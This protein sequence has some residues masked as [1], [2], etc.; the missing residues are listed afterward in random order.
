VLDLSSLWAGP[1]CAH[2]LGL[3]GARVVKLESASRPDG[4][5]AGS[6]AFFDLLN[7]GKASV[8]LDLS[9]RAGRDSLRRLIAS[10]DIVIE[11]AR[12][13]ALRQLGIEAEA[14]VAEVPGLR[15]S[16]SPATAVTRR[17][18]VRRRAGVAGLAAATGA[19]KVPLLRGR[20]RR[21]ARR[22]ACG[23]RGDG[24]D[25]R[26]PARRHRAQDVVAHAA[27]FGSCRRESPV[28]FVDPPRCG[29]SWPTAS[30]SRPSPRAL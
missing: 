6:A 9:S 23:G 10:S 3:A 15:G 28:G 24:A 19:A 21:P 20:D 30:D 17:D 27:A 1:L 22:H 12:P 2:L 7:A 5:R 18:R 26:R 8:A 25:R 29:K 16:A 13:R 11:S 14:L 4:A